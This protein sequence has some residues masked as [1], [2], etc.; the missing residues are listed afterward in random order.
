MAVENPMPNADANDKVISELLEHHKRQLDLCDRLEKLADSLP[1]NINRQECLSISWQIYPIVREAHRFEEEIL[2]P[3][4]STNIEEETTI[5]QS[6]ER[7]LRRSGV[8]INE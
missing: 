2:F 7:R 5:S 6:L 4:V 3:I 1:D 8:V